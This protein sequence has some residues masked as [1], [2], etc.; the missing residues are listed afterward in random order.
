MDYV[1]NYIIMGLGIAGKQVV[2]TIVVA[3]V[4]VVA[5]VGSSPYFRRRNYTRVHH[6][7]AVTMHICMM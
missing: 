7:T 4:V 5:G 1:A 6:T 3:G 2:F